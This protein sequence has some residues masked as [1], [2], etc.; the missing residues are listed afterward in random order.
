MYKLLCLACGALLFAASAAH[1][2]IVPHE[3][4]ALEKKISIDVV[5]LTLESGI[6]EIQRKTRITIGFDDASLKRLGIDKH[7]KLELQLRDVEAVDAIS[8]LLFEAS[9]DKVL[10]AYNGRNEKR[11]LMIR[12]YSDSDVLDLVIIPLQRRPKQ[13]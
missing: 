9:P 6:L 12:E 3:Y 4:D 2:I 10:A 1:G 7:R 11:G 13:P 8:S 5:P